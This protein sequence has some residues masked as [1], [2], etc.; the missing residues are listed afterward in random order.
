MMKKSFLLCAIGLTSFG[1]FAQQARNSVVHST[2][3]ENSTQAAVKTASP[4]FGGNFITQSKYATHAKVAATAFW[5]EDFSTGSS[6]TFPAGW[7][8]TKPSGQIGNWKWTKVAAIGGFSIGALNSSTAANG[9]MIFDS[10]S[11]GD[12]QPS[13]LPIRGSLISPTINCAPHATVMATFQ[14]LYRKFRD[15]TYLDVSNDGG[16][17][18]TTY[19]V[20]VNNSMNDNTT[21]ANNPTLARINISATAAGQANVKLRFRYEDNVYL[22]GTFNWLVD[23]IAL[24]ELDPVD[25]GIAG[26]AMWQQNGPANLY[27]SYSL[28]SN[29]PLTLVDSLLPV[30]YLT[31]YGSNP[32]SNVNTNVQLFRGTSSI[33][34]KSTIYS[35]LPYGAADSLNDFVALPYLPTAT[36]NFV[37]AFSI[38]PV[39]DA[40]TGNNIDSFK[41]NVTDSVY[42]TF[43]S[44]VAGGYYLH[45]PA[46]AGELTYYMGARFDIPE[47]HSDTLSSVSVSFQSGSSTGVNTVCQVYKIG[48]PDANSLAWNVVGG[49]YTKTLSA[50][51]ISTSANR[52]YT[53]YPV[54]AVAG[55]GRFVLTAGTYAIVV[56]T[57]AAPSN[58]TVTISAGSP[59]SSHVNF[60]G[61]FGQSDTSDNSPAFTFAVGA[62]I[63]TGLTSVPLVRANFGTI[64]APVID[65]SKSV[66][67][68]STLTL[69]NAYPNPANNEINIPMNVKGNTNATVTLSNAMGQ[70]VRTIKLNGLTTGQAKLVSIPT[71]DLAAGIYLYTIEAN[72]ER[73]SDRVIIR[74]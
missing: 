45:K 17:T 36:G 60:T 54:N 2:A 66:G 61:Y 55:K 31:N 42:T 19:P 40:F 65:T 63:R 29:I 72:G 47:G 4:V 27:S 22:G 50:A 14:Q 73:A 49:T 51:D 9:W 39:N 53:N 52:V 62:G 33:Y 15:S 26:S 28:F 37:A 68:I 74:R 41:F 3:N 57:I 10:D 13:T 38:N 20:L 69:G 43:G 25:L 23:D 16:S 70:V 6:T 67:T 64:G 24:T 11:I 46:S 44:T 12:L 18:W 71:S 48:G 8:A 59:I 7:S 21:N 34:A 58:S 5:T 32:G 56:K 35:A 1:A 30:T